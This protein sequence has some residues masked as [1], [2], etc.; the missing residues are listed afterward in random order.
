MQVGLAPR[1]KRDK[2]GHYGDQKPDS[3]GCEYSEFFQQAPDS[4]LTQLGIAAAN[5]QFTGRPDDRPSSER[6][7]YVL[8]AAML[9]AVVV[10]GG[11]ALRGLKGS[12]TGPR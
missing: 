10:L 8:W 11:L 3:A 7:S 12:T 1:P 2:T 9:L 6:H 5:P 4:V